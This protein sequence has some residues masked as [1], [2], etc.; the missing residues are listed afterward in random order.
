MNNLLAIVAFTFVCFLFWQQR[1]QSEY[2]NQAIQHYCK[3][4]ELQ[5]LSVARDT[6][7]IRLPSGKKRLH[8]TYV[9]EFSSVGDDRYTGKLIMIGFKAVKF[10]LPAYRVSDEY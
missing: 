3:K 6:Y 4:M 2:A 5:L 10:D 8:T 9:F 1:R 7:G